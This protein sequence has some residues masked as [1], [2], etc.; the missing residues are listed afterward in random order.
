MT[1]LFYRLRRKYD[2]IDKFKTPRNSSFDAETV[3]HDT[4]CV[5]IRKKSDTNLLYPKVFEEI[6]LTCLGYN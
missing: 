3:L 2:R 4:A 6:F 5:M 1:N